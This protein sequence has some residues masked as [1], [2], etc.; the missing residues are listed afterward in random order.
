MEDAFGLRPLRSFV[1]LAEELHFGRAARRLGIAQPSLTQQIAQLERALGHRAF[2]RR[3]RV[4]LTA[5]G[6][7]LLARARSLVDQVQQG[8]DDAR[9]AGRGE[10]GRLVLGF[11]SSALLAGLSAT[12]RVYQRR[13]PQVQVELREMS[14]SLHVD[15]LLSGAIDLSLTRAPEARK[16]IEH[17]RVHRERLM[18]ALPPGHGLAGRPK[19]AWKRLRRERF[20]LF[21]RA[22]NPRLHGMIVERCRAAGFEP[23]VVQESTETLTLLALVEAGMGVALLPDSIR[24]LRLG[25]VTYADLAGPQPTVEVAVCWRRGETSPTAG[26]FIHLARQAVSSDRPPS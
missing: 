13:F 22:H 6:E 20:L 11:G 9:R 12:L 19:V 14:S 8:V 25:G 5:A 4:A 24:P 2:V 17:L 15:A 10:L 21:P 18:L 16:G 1:V 3:P 23:R 7:R 26:R